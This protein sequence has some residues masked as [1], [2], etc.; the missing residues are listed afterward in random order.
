MNLI[1]LQTHTVQMVRSETLKNHKYVTDKTIRSGFINDN[2]T[3]F[4]SNITK[5][6]VNLYLTFLGLCMIYVQAADRTG[7]PGDDST[8]VQVLLKRIEDLEK[9]EKRNEEINEHQQQEINQL[10][11]QTEQDRIKLGKYFM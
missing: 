7:S 10:K 5:M 3:L 11:R 6:V 1:K 4:I 9:R 2:I 8:D